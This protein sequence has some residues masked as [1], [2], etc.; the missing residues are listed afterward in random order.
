MP[1]AF[2]LPHFPLATARRAWH[3]APMPDPLA[4]GRLRVVL[5]TV[6]L[7]IA[8]V[9]LL[10]LASWSDWR[11]GL[12]LNFADNLLLLTF[13]FRHGDAMLGRL[14]LFGLAVGFAE[15]PA[16]AW[17]VDG[18]LTLDYT[19]GGGPMLWRSPIW[20]PL[21]WQ[22]LTVQF[23]CIGLHLLDRF[24]AWGIA[25]I[26]LLGAVNI[27]YYEEMARAIHWWQYR[28]C[29]MFLHTPYYIILGETLIAI[30]LACLAAWVRRGYWITALVLG[31]AGGAGIFVSYALAFGVTDD[32]EW[33]W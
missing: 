16:D 23:A 31:I 21:A 6:L 17:L 32:I 13:M 8:A 4:A 14:M 22:V 30:L 25:A 19:P 5:A 27:P 9:A 3:H 18:T 29:R 1:S 24:R 28:D 11:T 10:T 12:A 7:N 26:G 33:R 2:D 15:L 20:M